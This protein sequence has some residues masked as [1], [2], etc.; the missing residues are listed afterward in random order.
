[1]PKVLA[2]ML[3]DDVFF[4]TVANC[5]LK[6]YGDENVN[7]LFGHSVQRLFYVTLPF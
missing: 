7:F 4:T 2:F 5:L 3:S 1:M 6:L